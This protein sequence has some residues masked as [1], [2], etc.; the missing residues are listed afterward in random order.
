MKLRP[1]VKYFLGI[2][3]MVLIL[4]ALIQI[5]INDEKQSIKKVTDECNGKGYGIT[6]RYD[7]NGEKYY[8]CDVK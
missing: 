3:C 4:F 6:E 1:W 8:T 2:G 5:L 7:Q